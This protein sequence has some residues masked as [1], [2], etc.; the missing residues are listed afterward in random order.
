MKPKDIFIEYFN[1]DKNFTVDKIYFENYEDA[2][3]WAKSNLEKFD[4][5][6]IKYEF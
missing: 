5:D 3:I 2:L 4:L 1:R 6:M